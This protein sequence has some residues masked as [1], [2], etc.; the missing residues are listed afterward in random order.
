[1]KIAI[2]ADIHANFVALQ[3]VA[4]HIARWQ[5]DTVMVAGDIVNRGPRSRECLEFIQQQQQ[6]AGWQVVKGNHEDYV[7]EFDR[8]ETTPG[9]PRFEIF[10]MAHWAYQQLNGH[11][12]ALQAMPFQV[13]LTGPAGDEMRV[14]HAS[15]L[16]NR[17][18]IF[19]TTSDAHLR[20]K[21]QPPPA[22]LGVGHT[23]IPLVRRIDNTL[24]VNAG[25]V[26]LPFDGDPRASYA[27]VEWRRGEWSA[28][29]VRLEYDRRRAEQDFFDTDF[30]TNAGPLA[31]LVLDELR[32][33]Q[34]RLYQWT[35]EYQQAT[36]NG[37]ISLPDAVNNFM[38]KYPER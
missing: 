30:M 21:I 36:L 16:N 5:P 31:L 11:V 12:R 19:T 13:S 29:I 28:Q 24:V 3:T 32:T 20:Q 15:M 27:Q 38:Q 1:M 33:A 10:Q 26:G 7:I 6:T 23:H 35:V 14:V 18:G 9:G 4:G 8:P 22:V 25:A 34:S 37:D 2:I 17:N